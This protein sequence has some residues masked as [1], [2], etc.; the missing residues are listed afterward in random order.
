MGLFDLGVPE[1]AF[2][3]VPNIGTIVVKLPPAFVLKSINSMWQI[4]VFK[5]CTNVVT[6]NLQGFLL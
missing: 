4:I 2:A 5:R 1:L 6:V 3:T